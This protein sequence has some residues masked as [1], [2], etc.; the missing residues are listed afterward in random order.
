MRTYTPKRARLTYRQ[1]LESIRV[2]SPSEQRRLRTELAKLGSV[3]IVEP[4]G[5]ATAIRRGKRLAEQVRK[6]VNAG[7]KGSLEETMMGL[8]GRSW[9]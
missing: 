4:V 7:M 2:L 5:T 1:I 3:H 8:R 9:S 6:K